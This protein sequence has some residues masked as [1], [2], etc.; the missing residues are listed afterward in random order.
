MSIFYYSGSR[1]CYS[2][3]IIFQEPLDLLFHSNTARRLGGALYINSAST[4]C[5]ERGTSCFFSVN[6]SISFVKLNFTGNKASEG[7]SI[8]GGGIQYCEVEVGNQRQRGYKVLQNLTKMFTEINKEYANNDPSEIHVFNG[9]TKV[10]R[11]QVFNISVTV[12]GEFDV[13]INQSVTFTIDYNDQDTSS[14]VVGQPYN[15]LNEK[16]CRNLGFR[17]L[18]RRQIEHITLRL[19]QCYN[20]SSSLRVTIHLDDCPPGFELIDNSCKCQTTIYQVT[21]LQDLC[22]SSTRLI[23]C[24]QQDWMKPILDENLTY[25]GFMWSPNCPAHL[26]RSD[27]DNWLDFSSDNVDFLCLEYRTAML[28]GACL[29]NYSLTLSSLKCSKCDSNNYLSLLLVFALA[30]VA[31]IASLLLLH[32]TVAD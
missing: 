20:K 12:L 15:N 18:S 30:G 23:K 13:P 21:R 9:T 27:K 32:M 6:G 14:E 17:I 31:L 10:Q 2:N 29:Q 28:C 5:I 26:C 25:E 3:V 24:P 16:G 19:P 8:Y 4:G 1:K 7:T 11:D 22:I